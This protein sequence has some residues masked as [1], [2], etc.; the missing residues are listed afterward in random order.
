MGGVEKRE[1]ERWGT[2]E[3]EGREGEEMGV[4]RGGEE[5]GGGRH[6]SQ[7]PVP[8]SAPSQAL[9]LHGGCRGQKRGSS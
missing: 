6:S 7:S 4:S 1:G 8:S 2:G 5:E 3:G 9:R